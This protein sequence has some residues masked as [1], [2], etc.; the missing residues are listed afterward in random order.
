MSLARD[1]GWRLQIWRTSH[2]D[3]VGFM[4]TN[5]R[6]MDTLSIY[7][8]G[9]GVAWLNDR[10]RSSDP[11][12][13]NAVALKLALADVRENVAYL[14]RPCQF[15]ADNLRRNCSVN[16]W[17]GHRFSPQVVAA[18][19]EAVSQL[20]AHYAAKNLQLVGYSGGGAIAALVAARRNDVKRL[21]TVAGNLDHRIWTQMHTLTPL[22]G[23]LNPVDAWQ[24]LAA[25]PQV[26]FVGAKDTIVPEAVAQ[27]YRGRFPVGQGP[28]IRVIEQFDHHCCWVR[29]WP[30]LMRASASTARVRAGGR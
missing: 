13:V 24:H 1:A 23:S 12:P 4:G 25:I 21:V 20:K 28:E 27:S 7:I 2:F 9:D 19:N 3:L 6:K 10:T 17:T 26:H 30:A 11:T 5:A 18:M 22:T 29:D 15:V 8:E 14:A 16:Y